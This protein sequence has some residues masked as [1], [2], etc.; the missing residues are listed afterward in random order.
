YNFAHIP[1]VTAREPRWARTPDDAVV[2]GLRSDKPETL[3]TTL[4]DAEPDMVHEHPGP[5]I[6]PLLTAI[7]TGITFITLIF[8]PWGL[9]IGL[10]CV[11]PGLLWW[12]WP[13]HLSE[14]PIVEAP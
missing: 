13:R 14:P 3:V 5:S 6:A 11:I 9:V 10:A 12:G 2:S 1:V 7:G 8:T 4:L